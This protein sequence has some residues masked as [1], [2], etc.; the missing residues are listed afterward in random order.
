MQLHRILA[1]LLVA[2]ALVGAPLAASADRTPVAAQVAPAHTPNATAVADAER[3][4][5]REKQSPASAKF[6][7]GG[8][9]IYIG[10]GALTVV[11]IILLIV[12]IL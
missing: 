11:L 10:G 4:A 6:E 12:I 5:E 9:A 8:E 2:A 3:Y 1:N 7:G